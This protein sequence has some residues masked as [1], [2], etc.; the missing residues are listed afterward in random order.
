MAFDIANTLSD[1]KSKFMEHGAFKAVVIGEPKAPPE[2]T[3]CALWMV[4]TVPVALTLTTTV[5][6]HVVNAR[7]HMKALDEE[8][9]RTELEMARIVSDI[10]A[11]ILGDFDLGATVR[12]VDAA[13]QYGTAFG[14]Q[15]GYA[16]ISHT[17]F[18]IC[19][20]TIPLIVDDS[21]TTTK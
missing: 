8:T 16:D 6:V 19:D 9:E 17:L 1:L 14:S 12:N 3:T 20:I 4:S 11:D 5:E 21:A 2:D 10:S 15:W 7:V 13:G 18:R